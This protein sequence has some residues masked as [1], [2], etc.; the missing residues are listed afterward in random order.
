[1]RVPPVMIQRHIRANGHVIICEIRGGGTENEEN[2]AE[3]IIK[4]LH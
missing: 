2:Q 4:E 1:M 3:F